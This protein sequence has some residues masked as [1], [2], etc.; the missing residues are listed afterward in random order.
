MT[1]AT[2]L[3][4]C[5]ALVGACAEHDAPANPA[6][7]ETS[8]S[9]QASRSRIPRIEEPHFR[10]LLAA[11]ADARACDRV[12]DTYHGLRAETQPD[13]VTGELWIR[14]CSIESHGTKIRFHFAGD[15]WQRVDQKTKKIGATFALH[16]YVHFRASATLEGTVDLAY[17]PDAHVA[18]VW[19]EPTESPKVTFEPAG[20]VPI[21]EQ[22]LWSQ[23]VGTVASAIGKAPEKEAEKQVRQQGQQSFASKLD[24]GMTITV[25]ACNGS[26]RSQFGLLP[27]GKEAPLDVGDTMKVEVEL[28]RGGLLIFGPEYA[29]RPVVIASHAPSGPVH[30]AVACMKEAD[31]LAKAYAE[32]AKELPK[33]ETLKEAQISDRRELELATPSCPFAVI[34]QSDAGTVSLHWKRE[35]P[36]KTALIQCPPEQKNP[37]TAPHAAPTPRN[38]PATPSKQQ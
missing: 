32:G 31:K 18:T 28:H 10:E 13:T 1:R 20:K 33:I 35:P 27:P 21:D 8:G 5:L 24:D 14:E 16:D 29:T 7:T 4:A 15:G 34:A 23:I 30:V 2:S 9:A 37:E 3:T 12:R 25:N 26:I 36:P 11:M 17:T 38:V 22:G 6:R 19:F